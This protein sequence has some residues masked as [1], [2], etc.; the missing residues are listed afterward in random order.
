[1]FFVNKLGSLPQPRIDPP[2]DAPRPT[3]RVL[4]EAVTPKEL[5]PAKAGPEPKQKKGWFG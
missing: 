2:A 3:P 1:M 4:P 5:A